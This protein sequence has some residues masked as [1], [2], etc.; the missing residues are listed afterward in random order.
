MI[1][2]SMKLFFAA[3]GQAIPL[4][5]RP[6]LKRSLTKLS[7]KKN[8]SYVRLAYFDQS[9]TYSHSCSHSKL[10]TP[11]FDTT[12]SKRK[13]PTKLFHAKPIASNTELAFLKAS[14]SL[15]SGNSGVLMYAPHG[16]RQ[17]NCS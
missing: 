10:S 6:S 17:P 5:S 2:F 9:C 8:S 7:K 3:R 12:P 1:H 16:G 15:Q 4:T 11:S 13:L 14:S